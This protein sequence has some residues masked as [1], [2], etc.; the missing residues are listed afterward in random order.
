[1][2]HTFKSKRNS[3]YGKETLIW[4]HEDSRHREYAE[5]HPQHF[6][7]S[8]VATWIRDKDFSRVFDGL[9]NEGYAFSIWL[10]KTDAD[11]PMGIKM[12]APDVPEDKLE[13][14]GTWYNK[15]SSPEK[16]EK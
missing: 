14:I 10:V 6:F 13:Y 11:E 9:I 7:G 16:F 15:Q 2:N 8:S 12:Y 4:R 3:S 1:M 5:E